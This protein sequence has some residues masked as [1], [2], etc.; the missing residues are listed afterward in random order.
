MT[1]RNERAKTQ[2]K[3]ELVLADIRRLEARGLGWVGAPAA[4]VRTMLAADDRRPT[5]IVIG[6]V[7]RSQADDRPPRTFTRRTT[8]PFSH[9][10][11]GVEGQ[12]VIRAI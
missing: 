11:C 3:I 2:A 12:R 5:P 7:A 8:A 4:I 1:T 9:R 6:L 10:A